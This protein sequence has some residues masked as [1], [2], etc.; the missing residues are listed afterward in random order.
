MAPEAR[1]LIGEARGRVLAKPTDSDSNGRFGMA[2]HAYVLL[3]ESIAC[4]QRAAAFDSRDWRWP[5]YL[6]T[7]HAELGRHSE[8]ASQFQAALS[9]RPDS[10]A[11][12]IRLG[13]SLLGDGQFQRAR[14]AF[15]EAVELSPK[16][17]VG[18]FGL[19]KALESTD[20]HDEA[21]RAYLRSIELEPAAG[22]VRYAIALLY[23]NL[24]R[25]GEAERQLAHV[26]NGNRTEP[27]IEDPLMAAVRSLRTDKRRYL[28]EGLSLEAE[29][30]VRD[31]IVLYEKAVGIDGR[32]LQARI[33]LIAAYG[34][35]G[36]FPEAE[37]HYEAIQG[38]ASDSEELH[39]NWGV[40]QAAQ[41]NFSDAAASYRRALEINPHSADTHGDLGV[42][43][44][45]LGN[46]DEA[47]SHFRRAL[48]NEPD[49]RL[50][51]F[52]LARY[53]IAENRVSEAI[54]HLL[55]TREPVDDRTPTYLYGLADAYLRLGNVDLS[56]RYAK[57]SGELASKLGQVG[58]ARA[59]NE[60]VR[61]LEAVHRR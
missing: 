3:Q 46:A 28:Q 53:L 19:G 59:I 30:K 16:S 20:D 13:E 38:L 44:G 52:H 47:R 50:A 49:H 31:A 4:Y 8:A 32:Y 58:L 41:K 11:A 39:V 25:A 60:D 26:G 29:G 24:G 14:E 12:R 21:L 5:Y 55:R 42:I 27:P 51:N 9:L 43:L 17:A 37:R 61:R 2:L 35:L 6:G 56:L 48:Q 34:K 15:K 36:R 18:Y 23:R 45:E 10:V 7:V 57:Q 40:L 1:E 22:S 54:D 33:N